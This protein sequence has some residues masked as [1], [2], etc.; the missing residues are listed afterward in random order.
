M[1]HNART[2][3]T[4]DSKYASLPGD[5]ALGS[6]KTERTSQTVAQLIED[7]GEVYNANKAEA[8]GDSLVN[9][10]SLLEKI[11]DRKMINQLLSSQL[12]SM[13]ATEFDRF[14]EQFIREVEANSATGEA[15]PLS[16]RR[17]L[18]Y[19]TVLSLCFVG[20]ACSV[21]GVIPLGPE[22]TPKERG[23]GMAQFSLSLLL[24]HGTIYA[25]AMHDVMVH[26]DNK[27]TH[28][29][30]SREDGAGWLSVLTDIR[31][32]IRNV[33]LK[34]GLLLLLGLSVAF[35]SPMQDALNARKGGIDLVTG[36]NPSLTTLGQVVGNIMLVLNWATGFG[37]PA[38][39]AASLLSGYGKDFTTLRHG[40]SDERE[41]VETLTKVVRKNMMIAGITT[42]H[43]PLSAEQIVQIT[44]TQ[45]PDNVFLLQQVLRVADADH[46]A[47]DVLQLLQAMDLDTPAKRAKLDREKLTEAVSLI[48]SD[49]RA[50]PLLANAL[51]EMLE[52]PGMGK[53]VLDMLRGESVKYSNIAARAKSVAKLTFRILINWISLNCIALTFGSPMV[54][55][56]YKSQMK[57]PSQAVDCN[58][59][60]KISDIIPFSYS[61]LLVAMLSYAVQG[62]TLSDGAIKIMEALLTP[63]SFMMQGLSR[64]NLERAWQSIRRHAEV[65]PMFCGVACG[66]TMGWV[67]ASADDRY[68]EYLQLLDC[69]IGV[70]ESKLVAE[71]KLAGI[72]TQVLMVIILTH[73]GQSSF[74]SV[75]RKLSFS[76]CS[77]LY[78]PVTS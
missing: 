57:D 10:T 55:Q 22:A 1:P 30:H 62:I 58:Y 32:K 34:D 38:V 35:Y 2:F 3:H 39:M 15:R 5:I 59:L 51:A 44:D 17:K 42:T 27:L 16:A 47:K 9:I 40:A 64:E 23:L 61:L 48:S 54:V 41:S 65:L 46:C 77:R 11:N 6:R 78:D 67:L 75:I 43:S 33:S 24:T 26:L 66:A 13:T 70:P 72:I 60:Q 52:S 74:K 14:I 18:F 56:H 71:F 28:Y 49:T 37:L 45:T 50:T 73:L 25:N 12:N 36:L 19:G 20:S 69:D 4:W 76:R 29:L 63:L 53:K 31:E 8:T 68:Q 21:L 7:A